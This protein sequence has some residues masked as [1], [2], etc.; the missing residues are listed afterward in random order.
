MKECERARGGKS[1]EADNDEDD[2]HDWDKN[3]LSWAAVQ[4]LVQLPHTQTD[5]LLRTNRHYHCHR[6][7]IF[8]SI[9]MIEMIKQKKEDA[10]RQGIPA[11][12]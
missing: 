2:S 10:K 1:R 5:K 3:L 7:F 12:R 8:I 11:R 9:I 4:P 6:P